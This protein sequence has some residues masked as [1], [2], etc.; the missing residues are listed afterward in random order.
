MALLEIASVAKA[1][2][3]EPVLG[4]ISLRVNAGE[5]VVVFGPSGTGKTVLLRI[6]AGLEEPG[7]G[8]ILIEGRDIRM[9]RPRRAA[10]AWRFRISPCSRI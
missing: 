3:K 5:I 4:D 10:S 9:C 2:G 1:F 7:A 6:I 8:S